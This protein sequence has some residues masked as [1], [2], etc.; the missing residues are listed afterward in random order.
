MSLPN[1]NM[2]FSAFDTLP[3]TE[4]DDLVEN[5]EALADGSGLDDG[6]ITSPKL[7]LT[8]SLTAYVATT[9]TTTS[10]SYTDLATA[11]PAVTVTVGTSG[12]VLVSISSVI[13][14]NTGGFDG[15]MGFALSGANTMTAQDKYSIRHVVYANNYVNQFG[16]TF[17]LTGLTPGSTVFTSKYKTGGNTAS[18]G[19]RH[20]SAIPL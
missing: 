8:G 2:D 14:N 11:G 10:T 13:N 3:A 7:N 20:L 5:I 12:I 6:A 4:L 1:P 15:F 9:Q 16:A 19:E 17:L 18:F